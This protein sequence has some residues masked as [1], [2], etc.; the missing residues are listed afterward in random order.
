MTV[1]LT[2]NI[3]QFQ[4][5]QERIYEPENTFSRPSY[6]YKALSEGI[7]WEVEQDKRFPWIQSSEPVD[8]H[9]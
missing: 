2:G 4:R 6:D 3:S 8:F 5:K 7:M 9:S 1:E